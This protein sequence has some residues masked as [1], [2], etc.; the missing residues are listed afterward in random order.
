MASGQISETLLDTIVDS[1]T[2]VSEEFE[3]WGEP[4]VRGPGLYVLIVDGTPDSYSDPMGSNTWPV[5]D[6]PTVTDDIEQFI[7]TA[8]SV[9]ATRD[10]A[11]VVTPDGRISEQMIRLHD[12]GG[13]NRY[14][15]NDETPLEY[16]DW[17]GARHMSA[18]EVSTRSNVIAAITLSEEDGRVSVFV[19]GEHR[20]VR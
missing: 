1:L 15:D 9:G 17:M 7:E 11:I 5:E 19:D 8:K 13:T 18:L 16:E 20:A 4:Y 12:M 3:R 6:C 10:G 14:A 2:V